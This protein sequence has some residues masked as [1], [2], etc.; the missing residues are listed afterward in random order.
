MSSDYVVERQ[1]VLEAGNSSASGSIHVI[2]EMTCLHSPLP[3]TK[4]STSYF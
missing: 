3:T 1:H 4:L 2:R